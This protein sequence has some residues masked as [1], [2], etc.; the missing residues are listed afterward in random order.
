MI[1][2]KKKD[3]VSDGS[4]GSEEHSRKAHIILENT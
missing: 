1:K 4:D 2:K 3:S